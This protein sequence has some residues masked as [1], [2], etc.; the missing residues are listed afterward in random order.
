MSFGQFGYFFIDSS[1]LLP[2]AVDAIKKSCDDFLSKNYSD[3]LISSSVKD[4]G[5]DLVKRSYSVV[6]DEIKDNLKPFLDQQGITEITNKRG[7]LFADFFS[8][9]RRI[10][11]RIHKT[12]SNVPNQLLGTIEN[13]VASRLHSLK[14]GQKIDSDIFLAALLRELS[15]E[16]YNLKKHFVKLC[17]VNI[18]PDDPL[19][20]FVI[21]RGKVGNRNDAEHLVSSIMH[22][23]SKN[24]WMI[25]ITNDDDHI[26]SNKPELLDIFALQCCKPDWADDYVQFISHR[27]APINHYQELKTYSDT[28]KRFGDH[29]KKIFDLEIIV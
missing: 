2:Q 22:Q 26:L 14:D 15:I 18:T 25:F 6:L 8:Q 7:R 28:Q 5:L 3:C 24:K 4:E 13:Y 27:K 1:I 11:K 9:R 21:S 16:K 29:I 17:C 19:T 12:G 23:F 20:C 10:I